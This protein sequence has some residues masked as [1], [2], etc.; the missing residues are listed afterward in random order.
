MRADSRPAVIALL[1]A[2][3]GC[4]QDLQSP[5][6]TEPAETQLAAAE[7]APPFRHLSAG[8]FHTCGVATDGK[9]YCWG[10]NPNGGLGDGTFEDRLRP[11]PVLG[12]LTFRQVS[13]GDGFSC[14]VTTD[15]LAYCWGWGFDGI[16]GNG[17]IQDSPVPVAVRGDRQYQG[18][19]S[20]GSHTCAVSTS[21][22]AFCWGN[23]GFGQLGDG[24]NLS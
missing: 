15:G 5:T 1:V 24:T 8:I 19:T 12:G 13:V 11:T 22:A 21:G 6:Q 10:R 23:N 9:A 20:G 7:A 18:I 2:L 16:L 14:G 3:T 4:Q 17:S